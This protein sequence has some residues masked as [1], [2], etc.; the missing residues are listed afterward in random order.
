MIV[1]YA[2][3]IFI[4]PCISDSHPH[5]VTNT[6]CRTDI[7]ISPDDG[8]SRP[9]HVEKRNKH[10]KKNCAP[11]DFIYKIMQGYKSTKHKKT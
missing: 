1:W 7:F 8:N 9:K 6:K 4:P 10:T 5:R 3:W 11:I 2:G